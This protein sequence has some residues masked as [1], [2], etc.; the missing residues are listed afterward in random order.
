GLC[1]FF[2][3]FRV[4]SRNEV[5][6]GKTGFAH[7]FEHLSFRGTP[8]VAGHQWEEATKRLGLDTNA[9]TSDDITNYHEA[10]PSDALPKLI[11]LEADRFLNLAY[12]QDDF[13]VE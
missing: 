13:K 2:T 9:Y 1:A 4:G 11:E 5:E 6:G 10:G 7:F 12:S 8:K 3:A